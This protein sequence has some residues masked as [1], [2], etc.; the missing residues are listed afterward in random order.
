MRCFEVRPEEPERRF[1]LGGN[2][3]VAEEAKAVGP[4]G[5]DQFS[6]QPISHSTNAGLSRREV[7]VGG[8]DSSP[9]VSVVRS[10]WPLQR[11][12]AFGSWSWCPRSF[13]RCSGPFA[14]LLSRAAG[15]GHVCA[16]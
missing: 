4:P 10:R 13:A 16:C 12:T 7:W 9:A 6:G 14:P 5:V 8:N 2:N 11:A 3:A 1:G 15:V